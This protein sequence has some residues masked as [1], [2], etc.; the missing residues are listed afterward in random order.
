M[1]K[2][3]NSIRADFP[4]LSHRKDLIYLDSAATSLM[5]QSVVD[6]MAEFLATDAGPVNRSICTL[7]ERATERYEAVRMQVAAWL[8]SQK[9]EIVF[10]PGVTYG[11]NIFARS[12]AAQMLQ[13]GDEIII[14]ALEHH[15]NMVVWQEIVRER[16]G[17]LRIVPVLADGTLDYEA[18]ESILSPR[19]KLVA[20]AHC[21]NV[22][23]GYLDV[24]RV[25]RAAKTV[26]ARVMLDAAQSAPHERLDVATLGVDAIVFSAHKMFGPTGVG[27]LYIREDL[28]DVLMPTIF[29][30]GMVHRVTLDRTNWASMPQR[31]EPGTPH[32]VGVIGLGAALSYL[33]SLDLS[34]L[35]AHEAAMCKQL[36]DGL[37][38][39]QGITVLGN[40]HRHMV[41]FTVAGIHP[42]DVAAHMNQSNICVRAGH[43][44]AQPLHETLGIAGS[45]RASVYAYTTKQDIEQLIAACAELTPR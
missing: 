2:K 37:L 6:A 8:G 28:H 40:D 14:S 7:G 12:W 9:H 25:V 38:A 17:L 42:H 32:A 39:L 23:G 41:S 4:L 35:R 36:V 44:C 34:S 43:H 24:A 18:F 15:A 33:G 5:P 1:L 16:G 21:S 13:Q 22:F 29:G 26:G 27:V 10:T 19:T 45:V 30:G 11:I 3:N 20:L 31:L